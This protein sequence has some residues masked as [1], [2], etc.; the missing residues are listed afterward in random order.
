MDF[1]PIF[2]QLRNRPCLVIGGGAVAERKVRQLLKSGA[3]VTINSPVLN[4]DLRKLAADGQVIFA[5]GPFDPQLIEQNLL[6]IAATS[7]TGI[8]RTVADV[9]RSRNRF[10]NVV[11]D[12]E[13]S[14]FIMPSVLDRS[15]IVV[16][17]SSGGRS[18]A[19]ARIVRQQID[20]WLPARIG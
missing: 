20:D 16:A 11:D 7:D 10:C 8:N 5:P 18:P 17:I 9:A 19:L 3:R 13:A 12:G 6:I 14:G 15:P 1:F 2:A 4:D